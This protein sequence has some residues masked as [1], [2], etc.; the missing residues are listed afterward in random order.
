MKFWLLIAGQKHETTRN[1]LGIF[2]VLQT[3]WVVVMALLGLGLRNLLQIL[4]LAHLGPAV[5]FFK[6]K[7]TPF[8]NL[9][10]VFNTKPKQV[11]MLFMF[12]SCGFRDFRGVTV[13]V[14]DFLPG[15]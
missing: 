12:F 8:L 7:W 14:D 3:T 6:R 1:V 5:I 4:N 2:P 10:G 11:N 13:N 9:L 15:E